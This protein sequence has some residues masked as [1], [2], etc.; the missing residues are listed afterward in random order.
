MEKENAFI[1]VIDAVRT[2]ASTNEA[3]VAIAVPLEHASLVAGLMSKV[4]HQVGVAFADVDS[5]GE[6]MLPEKPLEVPNSAKN[7]G[8]EAKALRLSSF[9]RTPAVWKAIGSD[10]NF[11]EWLRLQKC[12]KCGHQDYTG[13]DTGLMR[14]EAAHVRRVKDGSGTSIKPEYSAI[15]LCHRHHKL[16]HDKGESALAIDMDHARLH[17]VR[18]WAWESLKQQLGYESWKLVPPIVL[19]DWAER[20]NVAQYLP[21]DYK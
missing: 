19:K 10:S 20:N 6:P 2:R 15:P 16:Q 1:G 12:A 9:F 7:F 21:D 11:L 18:L 14:C 17:Y 5:Y 13:T 3:I 8:A 4:G